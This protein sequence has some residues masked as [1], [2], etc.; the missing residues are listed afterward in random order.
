MMKQQIVG[1]IGSIVAAL[2]CIGTPALLS[3]LTSIGA[4]FLI[5]DAILVPLLVIF[6]AVSIW[7][8]HRSVSK[9]GKGTP[10][11]LAVICSVVII[12]AIWF[13]PPLVLLGLV[14][15]IAASV[16]DIYLC[17]MSVEEV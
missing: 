10:R 2:C 4:G 14:S 16:W 6:L 7:G 1:T 15:L 11:T 9:H 3:L 8:I 12:I 5:R 13:S 17:R